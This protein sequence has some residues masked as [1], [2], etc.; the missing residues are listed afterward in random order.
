ME[1]AAPP[2]TVATLLGHAQVPMARACLASLLRRS[3][4]P[5][6]LRL[7]DDGTLTPADAE[8][9]AAALDGAEVVWRAEAD[10]RLADHLA[11]YPATRAYRAAS[12]LALKLVDAALLA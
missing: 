3:A 12:P 5:L 10:E 1:S 8:D 6:R 2:L 9:L 7:H 11:L 4:E